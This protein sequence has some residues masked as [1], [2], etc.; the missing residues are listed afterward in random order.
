MN[1]WSTNKL[2][3][4]QNNLREVDADM[5]VD[6]LIAELKQYDANA[7]MMNAGGMFAFYP[8][9]LADQYVTPY[10]KRDLLGEAVEKAHAA[11]IKFIARFDFSKA[12]ESLFHRNPEWFYRTKDG[13]E[14]N[15]NGIVHTCLNGYYQQQISLKMIEEV[16]MNY[17][18]DG[19]FF[20]MFGYQHWDYSG[21]HYG[22]C[23]CANCR[24]R[25]SDMYGLD[26]MEYEGAGHQLDG[27]YKQFQEATVRDILQRIQ[28]HVK[29]LRPEVAICTYFTDYVDIVRKESN[30]ALKRV[31]P[32]RLYSASENVASIEHGWDDKLVSNCCINA[33]DLTYRFTGVSKHEA[34]IRLYQ[35]IASGSGLDFCIIGAFEG[36]P[37]GD[38]LNAV[39]KVFRFHAE[40]E[41]YYGKL[42]SL[43]DVALIKPKEPQ[44]IKEYEGIFKML[45]EAHIQFDV[46]PIGQLTARLTPH[47]SGVKAIILPGVS[48]LDEE[49]RA[50]LAGLQRNGVHVLASGCALLN[51]TESLSQLFGA[52]YEGE[53]V[54]SP[55]SYVRV[56]DDKGLTS[57][58]ERTWIIAEPF[59]CM[60]FEQDADKRMPHV[61]PANFGPPERAYGHTESGGFG[62]GVADRGGRG[63]Y[64]SWHPGAQYAMHGFEDHKHAVID[65][66]LELMDGQCALH[67]DAPACTEWLLHRLPTGEHFVQA[68]NLS[69]Y[70]G[71]TYRAPLPL[72]GITV[73]LPGIRRPNG[74]RS[75]VTGRT[76][77]WHETDNGMMLE[78]DLRDVYEAIVIETP[79]NQ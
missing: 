77:E 55:A 52:A 7:W 22:P 54:S 8:T 53:I 48:M 30:T 45:K 68:L 10:L 33:I 1:W 63:A 23:Y 56:S 46:V 13:R 32:L 19:I 9:K 18:V 60:S 26:L 49:Q 12:H 69:G 29:E 37:D 43:A 58:G 51:D 38:N 35:N 44:A 16:I 62:L 65:V 6:K 3:L 28:K 64:F 59:A 78:L 74:V 41:H 31:D 14:V 73:R 66:L 39:K 79:P 70:N 67:T 40:H 36:Y 72:T 15:Y 42:E 17:P 47:L 50:G 25:F 5:D 21:N 71:S 20:N 2:R 76:Y 57:F 11:G 24:T 4:I 34:E 75:L 61:A 27:L